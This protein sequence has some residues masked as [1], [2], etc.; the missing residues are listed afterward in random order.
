MGRASAQPVRACLAGEDLD[1]LGGRSV[2]V[3]LDLCT[4]VRIGAPDPDAPGRIP[5]QP[6]AGQIWDFLRTRLPGLDAAPPA[7]WAC[8]RAPLAGGLSSSTALI[9]GLFEAFAAQWVDA[10]TLVRWAYEFEFAIFNGGGMDHLAIAL[11]GVTL[12]RGRAEGLPAQAGHVAFPAE[13]VVLVVDSGTSK[14]TRDHIRFVRDQVAARDPG[15]ARYVRTADAAGDAVWR[16]IG[17]RDLAALADGI[18]TAHTVMR[19]CQRMST[20]RL[21]RIRALAWEMAR[22]R[23]KVTGAGGG[24][25]LVGVCARA[26]AGPVA[27]VLDERFAA[28]VPGARTLVV[29]AAAPRH[30]VASGKAGEYS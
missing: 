21:E 14:D 1:W 20:P 24:G 23:L 17:R 19:D 12:L 26:D 25:A 22:V 18:E 13:W 9:L 2:C 10:A 28:E 5:V 6:W 29:E 8:G 15:L 16:A 11:G 7:T 30:G 4:V 3:A 27:R